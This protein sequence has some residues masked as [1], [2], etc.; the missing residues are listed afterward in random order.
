[1]NFIVT[2]NKMLVQIYQYPLKAQEFKVF[3]NIYLGCLQPNQIE[4]VT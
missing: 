2:N 4:I 3:W 1:M